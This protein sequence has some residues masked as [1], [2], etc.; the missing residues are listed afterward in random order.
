MRLL[1]DTCTFLWLLLDDPELSEAARGMFAD[2]ANQVFLSV[3]SC[4]E[5]AVKYAAG[6]LPLPDLPADLIPRYRRAHRI[7]SL[8]L[9]EAAALHAARLPRLH[10]DPFDRMLVCQAIVHGFAILTPDESI[11]QYPVRVL[12]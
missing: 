7:Q 2:P 10:A 1:L 4:W 11:A 12:W 6:R 8:P 5:I 9:D 3:V